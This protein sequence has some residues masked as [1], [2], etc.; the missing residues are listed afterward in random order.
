VSPL[1]STR[2]DRLPFDASV[3]SAARIFDY[4]LGGGHNF[5]ADRAAAAR[6]I[7]EFPELPRVILRGRG[8]LR[9]AVRYLADEQGIRQFLDLGSGIPTARNVHEVAIA[10]A[11]G[12]RVVY[13]DID[14]MAVTHAQSIL[15]GRADVVCV[16]G[17]LRDPG[18][19]LAHPKVRSVLDL[20]EPVGVLMSAVLHLIPG[21]EAGQIVDGYMGRVAP[22]SCLVVVHHTSDSASEDEARAREIYIRSV[23]Q[24]VPRS[25]EE[26][27]AFFHDLRLVDPGVVLVPLWRPDPGEELADAPAYYGYAAVGRK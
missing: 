15:R 4:L 9:R 23:R 26:I 2:T 25:R 8:F 14:P 12:A 19:L 5:A 22:G 24:L 20:S 3:P 13:V 27:A 7:Q 1:D 6:M 11:P 17:D 10:H 18:K 16:E 21:E